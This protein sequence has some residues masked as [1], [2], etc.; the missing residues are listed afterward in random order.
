[1]QNPYHQTLVTLRAE[2]EKSAREMQITDVTLK[3]LLRV[4]QFDGKITEL[5]NNP[6]VSLHNSST[7]GSCKLKSLG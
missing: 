5:S 2:R 4:K 6:E 3:T 1:M 7:T